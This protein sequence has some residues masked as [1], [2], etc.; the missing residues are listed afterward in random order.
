MPRSGF[1][2]FSA[3]TLLTSVSV[4]SLAPAQVTVLHSFAGGSADGSIPGHGPLVLSGSTLYGMTVSGGADSFGT[5]Y[6]VGTDGTGFS[7]LHSFQGFQGG[8]A[9]GGMPLGSLVQS[10]ST[11]HGF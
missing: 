11:L 9:A 3:V 8:A 4:G 1:L 10:G 2:S 6:R 7:L 5:V